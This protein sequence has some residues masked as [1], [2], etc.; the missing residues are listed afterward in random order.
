[1]AGSCFR[2]AAGLPAA[3]VSRFE[4]F[5]LLRQRR[6]FSPRMLIERRPARLPPRHEI[7]REAIHEPLS[8]YRPPYDSFSAEIGHASFFSFARRAAGA[9]ARHAPLGA[10]R[11]GR[12]RRERR[13]EQREAVRS[14]AARRRRCAQ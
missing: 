6:I 12:R 11:C 10:A 4:F 8:D 13:S 5:M 3:A 2:H 1:M 7:S 14:V 9:I